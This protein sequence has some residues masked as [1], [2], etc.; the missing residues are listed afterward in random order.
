MT[1]AARRPI[2]A[3]WRAVEDYVR[4]ELGIL[5][6]SELDLIDRHMGSREWASGIARQTG[7]NGDWIRFTRETLHFL[8]DFEAVASIVHAVKSSANGWV[9]PTFGIEQII[10]KIE[11]HESHEKSPDQREDIANRLS[12]PSEIC[13][14]A[15][16]SNRQ[17]TIRVFICSTFR[18]MHAERDLLA[19]LVFPELR[20]RCI[21]RG[22]DLV[23]ID[24]RWGVTRDEVNTGELLPRCL[25]EIERCRPYFIAMLGDRYGSVPDRIDVETLK[26]W[27]FLRE[28]ADRSIVEIE[29]IYGA[30]LEP[31][32]RRAL[33]FFREPLYADHVPVSA[34][35][36]FIADND[37]ARFRLRDLKSRVQEAGLQ[38]VNYATPEVFAHYALEKLWALL[39]PDLPAEQIAPTGVECERKSSETLPRRDNGSLP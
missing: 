4:I 36:D 8:S 7:L 6:K 25:T 10:R 13:S 12:P 19:R 5:S 30:L 35:R 16:K 23:E 37:E 2:E 33:F 11:A 21:S 39:A 18:D 26:S 1:A 28:I 29:I 17:D 27:P 34:R 24:L 15:T 31:S 38:V 32:A 9:P 20:E 14:H 22:V 3:F